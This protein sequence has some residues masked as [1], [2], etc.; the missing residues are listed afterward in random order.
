MARILRE[1]R[2]Y[3]GLT[4]EELAAQ[5]L[6]P[7]DEIAV[8]EDTGEVRSI[9]RLG[10]LARYFDLDADALQR[11]VRTPSIEP[12]VFFRQRG[13]PDFSE[14]DRQLL[15]SLVHAGTA[16]VAVNR[17]LGREDRRPRLT[18]RQPGNP[19]YRDGYEAARLVRKLLGNVAEPVVDLQRIIEDTF[20]TPVVLHPLQTT[21]LE[22]VTAKHPQADGVVIVLNSKLPLEPGSPS[23]R[24][25]LAH[26]LAHV[27]LDLDEQPLGYILDGP[28]RMTAKP[29]DKSAIEQRADAFAAE[30]LIPA[31]GLQRMHGKPSLPISLE[32]ARRLVEQTEQEFLAPR[33]LTIW[34]LF[35]RGYLDDS[36]QELLA[37]EPH[38]SIAS[39]TLPARLVEGGFPPLVVDRLREA[40]GREL[41]TAGRVRELLGLTVWDPLPWE[42]TT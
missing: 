37:R 42:T 14:E 4:R 32:R 2:S 41:L 38:L 16:L 20:E 24:R 29:S 5:S 21:R 10:R 35:N 17:L 34:H 33:Q 8:F 18:T 3:R 11:G 15:A 12:S 6:V 7:L 36:T 19:P 23:Y 22:A 40:R 25:N 39:P 30:L 27:L 28:P 31:A 9:A 26:E 1:E 13:A